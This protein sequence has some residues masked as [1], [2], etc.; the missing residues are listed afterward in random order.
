M[1][2]DERFVT[3]E[4]FVSWAGEYFSYL[5]GEVISLPENVALARQAA[6]LLSIVPGQKEE[7]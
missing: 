4:N 3:C 7:K 6:G 2:T 5:P 1:S